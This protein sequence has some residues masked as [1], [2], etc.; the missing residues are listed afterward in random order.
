M[1]DM[2]NKLVVHLINKNGD[3]KIVAWT[4]LSKR[5]NESQDE[6]YYIDTEWYLSHGY[7]THDQHLKNLKNKSSNGNIQSKC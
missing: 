2:D 4:E 6:E 7:V 1:K 5:V 3:R